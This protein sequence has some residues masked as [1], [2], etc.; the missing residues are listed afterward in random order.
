MEALWVIKT[1]GIDW[2]SIDFPKRGVSRCLLIGGQNRKYLV[3]LLLL[4][5]F[6]FARV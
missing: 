4:F 5:S 2:N 6:F 1:N 3:A